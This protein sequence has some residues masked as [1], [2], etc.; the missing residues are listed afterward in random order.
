MILFPEGLRFLGL[1]DESA[2]NIREIVYGTILIILM[3]YR[4]SGLKGIYSVK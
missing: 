2:A 1:P 3:Y 4:P